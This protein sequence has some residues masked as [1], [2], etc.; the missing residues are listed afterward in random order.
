MSRQND[1]RTPWGRAI[2]AEAPKSPW[3]RPVVETRRNPW[4]R[5]IPLSE[6]DPVDDDDAADPAIIESEKQASDL[7]RDLAAAYRR[8][9]GVSESASTDWAADIA[10]RH[11]D[12]TVASGGSQQDYLD[13]LSAHVADMDRRR[14]LAE[15]KQTPASVSRLPQAR[16]ITEQKKD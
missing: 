1:D 7:T 6:A 8:W 14:P 9:S 13:L 3:G 12:R 5:E 2:E 10:R 11:L 15:S 4:G 16:K